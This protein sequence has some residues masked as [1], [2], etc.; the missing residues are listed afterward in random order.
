MFC[1]GIILCLLNSITANIPVAE[2]RMLNSHGSNDSKVAIFFREGFEQAGALSDDG[3]SGWYA[4]HCRNPCQG[5]LV[6]R[7]FIKRRPSVHCCY[8][9]IFL[10]SAVCVRVCVCVCVSP[11]LP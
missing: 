3:K 6:T 1:T 10:I 2:G 5:N 11:L 4:V 7:I 8:R 9:Y